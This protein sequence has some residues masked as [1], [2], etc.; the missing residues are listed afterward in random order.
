MEKVSI[1][2]N[3]PF[4]TEYQEDI[5]DRHQ[6]FACVEAST[7]SGKTAMAIIRQ[8]EVTINLRENEKTVWV[9]PIHLQS[10]IAFDRM[11][12]QINDKNFMIVNESRLDIKLRT[13]GIMCFRSGDNPD[14]LYGD[15]FYY[16]TIDE[17]SRC[18]EATWMAVRSTLT[19]TGGQALLIG[20]VKGRKNWFYDLCVKA[21]SGLERDWYY[22]KI[23]AYDAVDAGILAA[24][25]IEA[26]K[27]DLPENVFRELYL[28]EPS[29]DGSNPFGLN[30]IAGCI[31]PLSTEPVVC[32]GIDLA[33]SVDW[34]VIIGLDRYSQVCDFRMFQKSW[35][36]TFNEILKLPNVPIAMDSTGAGDPLFERVAREK[37]DVEGFVFSSRSK[38]QIME[39]LSVAIQKRLISYPD[40]QIRDQLDQFEY[41]YNKVGGVRYSAPAGKHDD[42]VCALALAWHKWQSAS[43]S[44]GA[45]VIW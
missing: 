13:G 24:R 20:N 39:G 12:A 11:K 9:A 35:E 6:R 1:I 30:H 27:R 31:A 15:D 3:R 17:A 7:K 33:K 10:K 23:T 5:M 2:Y 19:A 18:K 16:A 4:V 43:V 26:A 14:A 45:P 36:D 44:G 29:E 8:L 25:E 34:T 40:G 38:Q 41:E 37:N 28:A 42:A 22:K 32:Y 21:K